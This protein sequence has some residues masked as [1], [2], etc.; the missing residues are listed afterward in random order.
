MIV[1]LQVTAMLLFPI[2]L[3]TIALI[4]VT[5]GLVANLAGAA[6]TLRAG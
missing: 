4:M 2:D 3:Q 6:T 1:L 5:A